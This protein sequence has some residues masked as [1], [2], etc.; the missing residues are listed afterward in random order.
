[1]EVIYTPPRLPKWQVI[2]CWCMQL[3]LE[4]FSSLNVESNMT[5]H[6]TSNTI[7]AHLDRARTMRD[8]VTSLEGMRF[9]EP[10]PGEEMESRPDR[11]IYTPPRLPKWQVILCWCSCS[12]DDDDAK[13]VSR[14]QK[15]HLCPVRRT[16]RW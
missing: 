5:L 9:N 7:P 1:M 16:R 2:L 10:S 14:R 4:A 8:E 6:L 12:D 15:H 11:V 3:L 13:F